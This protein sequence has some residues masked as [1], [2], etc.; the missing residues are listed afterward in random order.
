MREWGH[1]GAFHRQYR[2]GGASDFQKSGTSHRS[3]TCFAE[4]QRLILE[5]EVQVQA[6][7]GGERRFPP[8]Q[9]EAVE[10]GERRFPLI[11]V[12]GGCEQYLGT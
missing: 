1:V 8:V 3:S 5:Y 7:E 6:V 2:C 12:Q 9:V 11:Q 10:G 4:G